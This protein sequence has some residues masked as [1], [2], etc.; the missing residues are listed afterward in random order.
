MIGIFVSHSQYD[1]EL[2]AAITHAISDTN[3]KRF[4]MEFENYNKKYKPAFGK[5]TEEMF[6]TSALF[7]LL[8]ENLMRNS[9]TQNWVSNEI[10]LAHPMR[11]PI[12]VFEEFGREIPFPV[13][14]FNHYVLFTPAEKSHIAYITAIV[15]EI[16]NGPI[17]RFIRTVLFGKA[18]SSQIIKCSHCD[19][20]YANLPLVL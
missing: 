4:C 10:G 11:K 2:L 16:E 5:I 13:P 18:L 6:K 19:L 15:R 12:W 9:Y 14:Y 8:G 3:V 17:L 20:T 7:L 1:S